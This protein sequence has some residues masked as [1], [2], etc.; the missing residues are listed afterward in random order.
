MKKW[1]RYENMVGNS[2]WIR[3]IIPIEDRIVSI[4]MMKHYK[5]VPFGHQICERDRRNSVGMHTRPSTHRKRT[6]KN[7]ETSPNDLLSQEEPEIFFEE[8]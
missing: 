5:E 8:N 7:E 2:I 6:K 1:H 3:T 4:E